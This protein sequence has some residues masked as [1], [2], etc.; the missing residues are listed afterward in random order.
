[1]RISNFE[2]I[3]FYQSA[4]LNQQFAIEGFAIERGPGCT[5]TTTT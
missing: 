5:T 4:I 2:L 1:M 3:D